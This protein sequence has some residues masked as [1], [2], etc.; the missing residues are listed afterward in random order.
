M[1]LRFLKG[2][3]RRAHPREGGV[4]EEH[5]R[6]GYR[7]FLDRP[8]ESEEVIAVKTAACPTTADLRRTFLASPEFA[9]RNP[10][11][12]AFSTSAV[13][14]AELE[15][16]LRLF[17]DLADTEIGLP[18]V[19]GEYE[20]SELRFVRSAV[21]AGDHVLDVGANIGFFTVVLADQV[22]PAGFVHAFEPLSTNSDLLLRSVAENGF[23]DRV[24]VD[25]AA[26]GERTGRSHLL[27][28]SIPGGSGGSYL[29]PAGTEPPP[30]HG[31]EPVP[32]VALDDVDLRRPVAFLKI[33]VEGA[34]PLCFAGAERLLREDRPVILSELHQVQLDRVA[35]TSARAT[36]AAME[37]RGYTCR[38][39]ED[40]RPGSAID[41]LPENAIASVVFLPE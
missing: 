16:G 20:H 34:E 28:L 7:L 9:A 1:R 29:V 21:R 18:V 36:I 33:D 10:G 6:W 14:I 12:G 3:S 2:R 30:N 37:R 27:S 38:L 15:G 13:V 5:V 4:T 19:L 8:P 32:L 23:A 40:G 41:D 31:V 24:S 11:V 26:V 22:G 17:V 39:L 35:G 25:R